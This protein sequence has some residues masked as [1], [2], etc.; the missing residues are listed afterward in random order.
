M[1]LGLLAQSYWTVYEVCSEREDGVFHHLK[2][3]DKSLHRLAAFIERVAAH[4]PEAFPENRS[5]EV[6]SDP[7][8]WQFDITGTLRL[9][10]FYDEGRIVIATRAFVKAGGKS[11]QTP[12]AVVKAAIQ[13]R[14]DYFAAKQKNSLTYLAEE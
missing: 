14:S 10:Y 2:L 5:H 1:K 3:D 9:L 11:G 6:N 7:K 12:R 8:I 13:D 4:G